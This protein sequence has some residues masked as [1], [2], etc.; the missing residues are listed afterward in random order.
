VIAPALI[1]L[2]LAGTRPAPPAVSAALVQSSPVLV[3]VTPRR[4]TLRVVCSVD[5]GRAR[6][7]ARRT[8]LKLRPGRHTVAAWAIGRHRTRSA[9][10]RVTVIAAAPRPTSVAVGGQPVGIAATGSTLWVSGGSDG[11]AIRV[12]AA[13]RQVTARVAVG[14]QLGGIAASSGAVWVAVFDGGEVVR[15]DPATNAVVARIAVGGQ[16]TAIAFDPGGSVWVGNLDGTAARIS[17]ATDVVTAK[18]HFASGVS[19][20]LPL[21]T[22][23]WTGLQSGSLVT[24]DPSVG[25]VTGS[26]IPV[27]VDVDAI[28]STP[29][30]IW[31]STFDGVAV[32]IDPVSRRVTRHV[33]L[34]GRAGGIAFAKGLVWVSLYDGGYALELNPASGKPV[35]A[36]R[37][38]TQPRDSLVVGGTLWIVDQASGELTPVP[39]S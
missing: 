33:R 17:P 34:P 8:R 18:V 29:A 14:G 19:T 36:V 3:R 13:T 22:L 28:A 7:C 5:G 24:L 15:I 23:L 12:D 32:R 4:A 2:L 25:A 27:S 37:T 30:G 31:A 11:N 16:P 6:T 10:R 26:E 20:F 21:R 39:V 35:G 38:G 9:K 1:A